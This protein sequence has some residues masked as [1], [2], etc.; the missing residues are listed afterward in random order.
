MA[1]SSYKD[2]KVIEASRNF[3]NLVA[4]EDTAHGT[5]E[6]VVGREKQKL[7]NEYHTIPCET[8]K[9]AY[10]FA[11]RFFQGTFQTPT[12]VFADPSGKEISRAVG[13]LSAGELV[14]KMNEALLKVS[15][16]K[17]PL[18]VWQMAKVLMNDGE[19]AREKDDLKKAVEAYTK[20]SKLRGGTLKADADAALK[21]LDEEGEKRLAAALAEA[22]VDEKKK[23]VKKVADDFKPLP[24]SAKAKK[25]LD[26]IK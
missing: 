13:G 3:V 25:E 2:A 10:G 8:H 4:H 24:V 23:A 9:A 20:L 19:V 12:T 21:K 22:S 5:K 18:P 16:E 1:D 11:G 15:G 26:A 6:V 14:K 7:C 17:V